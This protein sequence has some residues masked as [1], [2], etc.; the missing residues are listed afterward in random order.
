MN[1][2]ILTVYD[3]QNNGFIV[4][5]YGQDTISM[6]FNFNSITT[7]EA[8]DV[9]SQEFRI[10]ATQNNCDLFGLQSDFNIVH[11]NDIRRKFKAILTVDTIPVSEGFVQF[12]KS[13]IKN[14]KM[15]DFSIPSLS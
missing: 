11:R 5:L 14:G 9:Y 13:F 4:D 3:Q 12:K 8:G 10:P 2:V 7:L 15:S 6:N 1:D